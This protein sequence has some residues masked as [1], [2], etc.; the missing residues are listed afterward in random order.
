MSVEDVDEKELKERYPEGS[1]E[2]RVLEYSRSTHI[3]D[4]V[5]PLL[6]SAFKVLMGITIV[7]AVASLIAFLS[8]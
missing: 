6:L 4:E 8:H 2:R 1:L 5:P 7:M 3:Q